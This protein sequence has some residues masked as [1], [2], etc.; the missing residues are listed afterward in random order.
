MS[1]KIKMQDCTRCAHRAPHPDAPAEQ[2]ICLKMGF[3]VLDSV[4][5]CRLW[6]ETYDRHDSE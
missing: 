2:H 5:N 6:K 4:M 1:S 3:R